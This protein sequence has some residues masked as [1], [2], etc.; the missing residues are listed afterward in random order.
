MQSR[1]VHQPGNFNIAFATKL[2]GFPPWR[3]L[4]V[5]G[6][7]S[8]VRGGHNIKREETKLSA[9]HTSQMA[10]IGHDPVIDSPERLGE[11]FRDDAW[12]AAYPLNAVSVMHYFAFSPFYAK[13]C[14]NE[15]IKMQNVD[16]S[17]S[18]YMMGVEYVLKPTGHE[19]EGLFVIERVHRR[20]ATD[21]AVLSVYYCLSGTVYQVPDLAT[22]L[23]ARAERAAHLLTKAI[24]GVERLRSAAL[25]EEGARSFHVGTGGG[26]A[27]VADPGLDELLYYVSRAAPAFTPTPPSTT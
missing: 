8:L 6:R 5:I 18:R 7:V 25:I 23:G 3:N 2:M 20:S 11:F 9:R 17:Q 22:L 4:L 12:L 13:D 10:E 15:R 24:Q 16:A 14:I 21:V 19:A 1:S 27:G 26:G